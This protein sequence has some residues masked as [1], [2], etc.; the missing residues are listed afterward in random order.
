MWWFW[1]IPWSNKV[2]Y[3][4]GLTQ[5]IFKQTSLST[6]PHAKYSSS[7]IQCIGFKKVQ[8]LTWQI[9][10]AV[11][12]VDWWSY[13]CILRADQ[14]SRKWFGFRRCTAFLLRHWVIQ[15]LNCL[16]LGRL[17]GY[18]VRTGDHFTITIIESLNVNSKERTKTIAVY[19]E[20]RK[21]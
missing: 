17:L 7:R 11:Y 16:H 2:C 5:N 6:R 9:I 15:I 14:S 21:Q 19:H 1:I 8:T 13:F 18:F 12:F 20:A 4:Y 3:S 10:Y